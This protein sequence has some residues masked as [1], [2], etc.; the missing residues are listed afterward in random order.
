MMAL[1]ITLFVFDLLLVI[2]V[3]GS[4]LRPAAKA[5]WTAVIILLPFLGGVVWLLAGMPP[6]QSV[7]RRRPG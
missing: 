1:V 4:R 3:V 2:N 5:G 7:G 6:S